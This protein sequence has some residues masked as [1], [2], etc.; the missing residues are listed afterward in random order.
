M[1]QSELE[2]IL[3]EQYPAAQRL[4]ISPTFHDSQPITLR[5]I[6]VLT[7]VGGQFHVVKLALDFNRSECDGFL[8]EAL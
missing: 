1:N 6:V 2:Q 8:F 5:A 7:F 3:F 4:V